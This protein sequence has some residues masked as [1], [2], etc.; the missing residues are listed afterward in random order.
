M[1]RLDDN[2]KTVKKPLWKRLIMFFL[3]MTPLITLSLVYFVQG[4]FYTAGG[5]LLLGGIYTWMITR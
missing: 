1:Y 4:Y 5:V 2:H 3:G